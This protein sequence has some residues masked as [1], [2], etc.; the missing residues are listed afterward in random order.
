QL[1][2]GL[3]HS[4]RARKDREILRYHNVGNSGEEPPSNRSTRM[5]SREIIGVKSLFLQQ[6]DGESI[7]QRESHGGARRRSK[8]V[9]TRFF[10]DPSVEGNVAMPGQSR[11]H[12]ARER[13]C[14]YTKA[15]QMVEQAEHFVGFAAL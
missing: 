10:F 5:E 9:R 6:R 12:V 2:D 7:T 1:N 8:I 3:S 4:R 11:F 15:L 13:N 14:A